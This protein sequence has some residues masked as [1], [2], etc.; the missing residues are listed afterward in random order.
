ME[1][2]ESL[3]SALASWSDGAA[4]GTLSNTFLDVVAASFINW[5]RELNRVFEVAP[6][7]SVL[8]ASSS[9]SPSTLFSLPSWEVV[10]FAEGPDCKAIPAVL[11]SLSSLCK[12]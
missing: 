8:L 9:S 1:A 11:S 12:I 7:G 5:Y 2:S 3:K 6:D 4:S 10:S